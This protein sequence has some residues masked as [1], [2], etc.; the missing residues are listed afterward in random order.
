[1]FQQILERMLTRCYHSQLRRCVTNTTSIT[2]VYS[3]KFDHQN[4]ELIFTKITQHK[5]LILAT[6]IKNPW[7]QWVH[8]NR[9]TLDLFLYIFYV[10]IRTALTLIR[11]FIARFHTV[12]TPVLY[13]IQR[14]FILWSLTKCTETKKCAWLECLNCIQSSFYW[15][16]IYKCI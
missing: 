9:K 11:V 6:T 7:L 2:R 16:I 4:A 10:R 15:Q 13:I 3:L 8:P 14:A 1:M 5:S 12:K